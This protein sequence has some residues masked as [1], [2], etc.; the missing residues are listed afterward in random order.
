MTVNLFVNFRVGVL[1]GIDVSIR[2]ISHIKSQFVNILNQILNL[3][4]Y[5]HLM[6]TICVGFEPYLLLLT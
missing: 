4:Y 3:K 2:Q 1:D 6:I 5:R